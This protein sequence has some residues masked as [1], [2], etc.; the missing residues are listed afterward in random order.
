MGHGLVPCRPLFL[1][2]TTFPQVVRISQLLWLEFVL[3]SL[4]P[5][6]CQSAS[7]LYAKVQLCRLNPAISSISGSCRDICYGEQTSQKG[8]IQAPVEG[9]KG[10]AGKLLA[11]TEGFS[12]GRICCPFWAHKNIVLHI[13][14]TF[15]VNSSNPGQYYIYIFFFLYNLK[16]K[17]IWTTFFV[18]FLFALVALVSLEQNKL[19]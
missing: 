4:V 15:L 7:K 16:I 14:L 8:A 18:Y 6:S 19:R 10:T 9:L 11:P 2:C 13:C 5:I 3:Q 17:E 1:Q 12:R